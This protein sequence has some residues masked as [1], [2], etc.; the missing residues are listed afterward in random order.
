MSNDLK[1]RLAG[2]AEAVAVRRDQ[3]AFAELFDYFAPRLKSYLQRLRMEPS[4]AEELTQEIMIVLWHKA[5]MFDPAKSSLA[6]W[7]FR[8]ARNRRIDALRRDRSGR[9]DPDD[10]ALQPSQ[11]EA[12]DDRIEAEQRDERVRKAMLDLPEE[13]AVLVRQAFFLG[14][15][16]SQIAADTGLPLGTV[17]SR[18]RLAFARL[19][20][21]LEIDD[22]DMTLH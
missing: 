6:T 9:L 5:G 2:L 11:P 7:L 10:P 12:A 1:E 8:V 22:G 16:H 4:Q 13:Q 19:R 14:L 17:K 20:R 18:I 21:S 3:K 15:S